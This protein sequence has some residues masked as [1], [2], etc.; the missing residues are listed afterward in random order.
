MATGTQADFLARLKAV[1]PGR[2]FPDTMPILDGVLSGLASA[3][4][5][6]YSLLQFVK[7][8][9][10]IATASG[11]YLDLIATDYFG[12]FI[13][14]RTNESD[15]NFSARICRE[16]FREKGTRAG[17]ISAL[18]ALTGRTPGV[19]EPAYTFET[20]GWETGAFAFDTAGGWG[21][22]DLPFQ[23]F[24]TAYRP[25]GGRIANVAGFY[26]GSGWSGG[27]WDVGAIEWIDASM[28]GSQVS[29][30]DIYATIASALPVATIGWTRIS[31]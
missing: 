20:G 13:L 3:W 16:L 26:T 15:V 6:T 25:A 27:G 24:I 30:A 22:L 12:F 5:T 17:L 4:A 31:S 19:F 10:R 29:D 2:W 7:A 14:R 9:A 8:Q 1:L 21:E 28:F 11:V 18:V 23:A